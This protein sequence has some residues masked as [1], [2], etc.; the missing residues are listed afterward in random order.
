[1]RVIIRLIQ[2]GDNTHHQDQFIYPVNFKPMKSIV[3]SPMK[4][5]FCECIILYFN[6]RKFY[7][8]FLTILSVLRFLKSYDS[9]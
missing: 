4:L 7:L 2:M 6:F 8:S 1:M 5:L 9:K 3:N